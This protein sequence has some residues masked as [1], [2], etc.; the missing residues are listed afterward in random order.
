MSRRV[1][2]Q[3]DVDVDSSWPCV[4]LVLFTFLLTHISSCAIQHQAG[5]AQLSRSVHVIIVCEQVGRIQVKLSLLQ[6]EC[7]EETNDRA[8]P[9]CSDGAPRQANDPT[10]GFP[11]V[12]QTA[13]ECNTNLSIDTNL[14]VHVKNTTAIKALT[15]PFFFQWTRLRPF[16][17]CARVFSP[18]GAPFF[19]EWLGLAVETPSQTLLLRP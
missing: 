19:K 15:P 3:S 16:L 7:P 14:K 1:A 4:L 2:T 6:C 12:S 18:C 13:A 5:V 10:Q 9:L 8:S 17:V 11:L